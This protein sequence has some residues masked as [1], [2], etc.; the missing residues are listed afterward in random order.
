MRKGEIMAARAT[1]RSV[2]ADP[3]ILNRRQAAEL[4]GLN[5]ETVAR[6]ARTGKLPARKVGR[7]WRF[8]KQ[9]LQEWIDCGG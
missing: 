5:V 3:N 7:Q 1:R 2:P 4:L 8:S 6:L 9:R